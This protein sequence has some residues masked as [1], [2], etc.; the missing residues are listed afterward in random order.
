MLV[1]TKDS[2]SR[3][4]QT[5][6]DERRAQP[7]TRL[8]SFVLLD[9]AEEGDVINTMTILAQA[10][11]TQ[12]QELAIVTPDEADW[13]SFVAR[14][15][16]G[17]L[18]QQSAWGKLKARF[19]WDIRRVAILDTAGTFV[20]GAQLLLRR[21][22]GLSIAYVPR[23]P[24]FAGTSSADRLLLGA[25]ARIARRQRAILLRI[26][27][28]LIE[29]DPAADMTHT[30]LLLQ[31]LR[32][33]ETI[34]PRS[35][36]HVDV[37]RAEAAIL[38]GCSKGHR[39]DIKRAE[40]DG[41]QV[42]VGDT[43]DIAAFYTIMQA[44]GARAGFGIH[45]EDYYRAAWELFQPRS[46]LLLAE[47]HGNIVAAHMVFADTCRGL[48]LYSGAAEAGLKSGANHLLEWQAIR[49]ARAI[50]CSSYDL[51]GIPD[52]LGRAAGADSDD[53]REALEAAAR[54]DPLTGVYRFKKG[55]GGQ[56]VRYLPAYD[57]VLIPPLYGL[58]RRQ[59]G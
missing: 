23:G 25:L 27:P 40:R 11:E 36:I 45:S 22:Y 46:R 19:G 41:V 5:T 15:P 13:D 12:L 1:L 48:Y 58:A 39:A 26:E 29:S 16:Q 53:E 4:G 10:A 49:W 47:L 9:K 24:L 17:N 28:N 33:D 57:Y 54:S 6:K 56:I 18:L 52:A 32:P 30:W 34:Q 55:F 44:T 42:R 20:S 21:Q 38:A 7:R 14:H 31:G 37:D 2:R 8:S 59:I 35:S 51:W 3:P 50:G 43:N